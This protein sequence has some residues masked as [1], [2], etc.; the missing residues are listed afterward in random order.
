MQA[1]TTLAVNHVCEVTGYT[2]NDP[3]GW[4]IVSQDL[5]M[6]WGSRNWNEMFGYTQAEM[7]TKNLSKLWISDEYKEGVLNSDKIKYRKYYDSENRIINCKLEVNEIQFGSKILYT[8]KVLRW[9]YQQI[10]QNEKKNLAALVDFVKRMP[11][12]ESDSDNMIDVLPMGLYITA[13]NQDFLFV[14]E[15]FAATLGYEKNELILTKKSKDIRGPFV[16]AIDTA[17]KDIVGDYSPWL[18]RSWHHKK[19]GLQWGRVKPTKMKWAGM[20]GIMHV[21]DWIKHDVSLLTS[22]DSQDIEDLMGKEINLQMSIKTMTKLAE[23]YG[24]STADVAG[25]TYLLRDQGSIT[26][27]GEGKVEKPQLSLFENL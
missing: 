26:I 19:G 20:T 15:N 18:L 8:G 9:E 21:V 16:S 27:D 7:Q 10:K 25:V 3:Q 1:A 22:I 2:P 11:T 6:I 5:Q 4:G 14:N 12:L 23:F 24:V 13:M 17:T